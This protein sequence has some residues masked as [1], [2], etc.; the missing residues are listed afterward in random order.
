MTT[1]VPGLLPEPRIRRFVQLNVG[2]VLFGSSLALLI[3][4]DLGLDPW[5]VLHQ[6]ISRTLDVRLGLAVVATSFVVLALWIPIRQR[7]GLGTVLN[8]ILVG[9]VFEATISILPETDSLV[10][11]WILLAAAVGV[12]AIATGMYVGAG[13]GPGP[14]DGLMTGIAAKGYKIRTV[15]TAIEITVLIAGW[16]LGGSVGIGTVVYALGIGPLVH[17]AL[18]F[19]TIG[20]TVE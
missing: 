19:F 9:L 18:P 12:N 16:I 6:G 1:V 5:D 20:E 2:L 7:P 4:A 11:R 15:R 8:A 14:R 17:R 10:V 13:L 3:T